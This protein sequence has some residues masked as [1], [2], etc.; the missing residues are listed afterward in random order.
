MTTFQAIVY[1]LVHALTLWLP[2]SEQAHLWWVGKLFDW[3]A[4]SG[5]FLGAFFLGTALAAVAFYIHDW[6]SMGSSMLRMLIVWRKPNSIDE[7][8]PFFLLLTTLPWLVLH[9]AGHDA[10]DIWPSETI[11]AWATVAGLFLFAGVWAFAFQWNRQNKSHLN[12][13]WFD[14]II[15]GFAQLLHLVPGAGRQLGVMALA[16]VRGY[17]RDAIWKYAILSFTPMLAIRAAQ[18]FREAGW[19]ATE[20]PDFSWL[21]WAVALVISFFVSMLV[22][23]AVTQ[24]VTRPQHKGVT[25]YRVLAGLIMG[26]YVLLRL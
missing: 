2:V 14:S 24:P 17:Q 1:G 9:V 15:V 7:R 23:N 8:M 21:S 3:P 4:P 19:V 25:R 16:N 13:N 22:F 12:W 26:V 6:L 10:L 5:V 18:L 11:A 20:S